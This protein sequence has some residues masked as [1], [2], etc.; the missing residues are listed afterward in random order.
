MRKRNKT[1]PP[2]DHVIHISIPDQVYRNL[3]ERS[4]KEGRS[5]NGHCRWILTQSTLEKTNEN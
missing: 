1:S 4:V 2:N 5:F 3:E